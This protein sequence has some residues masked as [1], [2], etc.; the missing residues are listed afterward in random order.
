MQL[1]DTTP[2]EPG[3][4]APPAGWQGDAEAYRALLRE[5]WESN[6]ATR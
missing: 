1:I 5:R 4:F 2:G 3:P 6:P